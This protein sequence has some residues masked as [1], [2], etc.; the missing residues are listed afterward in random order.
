MS[1]DILVMF[2]LS[3]DINDVKY[4]GYHSDKYFLVERA[5]AGEEARNVSLQ[6][7]FQCSKSQYIAQETIVQAYRKLKIPLK[8][9]AIIYHKIQ[10]M[11]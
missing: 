5:A 6:R 4:T 2:L 7:Y 9:K 1:K 3:T 10:R 11:H 8:T